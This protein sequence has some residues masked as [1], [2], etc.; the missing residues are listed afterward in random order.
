MLKELIQALVKDSGAMMNIRE[1]QLQLAGM[2]A[3]EQRALIDVLRDKEDTSK[4]P[5]RFIPWC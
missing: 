5:L 4:E 1:G 3:V 2:S